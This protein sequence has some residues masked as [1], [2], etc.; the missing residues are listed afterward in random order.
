VPVEV[1]EGG[2]DADAVAVTHA[3]PG[4]AGGPADPGGR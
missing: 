1:G 2:K 3:F 4:G